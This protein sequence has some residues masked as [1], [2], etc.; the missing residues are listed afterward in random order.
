MVA[1]S[2]LSTALSSRRSPGPRRRSPFVP[3]LLLLPWLLAV[4][5]CPSPG[6]AATWDEVLERYHICRQRQ[7][8]IGMTLDHLRDELGQLGLLAGAER[9]EE[10]RA[11]LDGFLRGLRERGDAARDGLRRMP[12]LLEEIEAQLVKYRDSRTCPECIGS[13]TFLLCATVEELSAEAQG[14]LGSV[15]ALRAHLAGELPVEPLLQDCRERLRAVRRAFDALGEL[16]EVE[17]ELRGVGRALDGAGAALGAGPEIGALV[18]VLEARE[19]LERL[20]VYVDLPP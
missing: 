15:R 1:L 7:T 14:C 8:D 2:L 16:G 12:G 5:V 4:S 10:G 17:P 20:A 18:R 11:A 3:A 9:G 6:R 13:S 19:A